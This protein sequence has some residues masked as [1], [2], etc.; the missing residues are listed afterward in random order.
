MEGQI[1]TEIP[2][3]WGAGGWTEK[4]Q[5]RVAGSSLRFAHTG[6]SDEDLVRKLELGPHQHLA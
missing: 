5:R 1:W 3:T 2:I 6:F 4:L